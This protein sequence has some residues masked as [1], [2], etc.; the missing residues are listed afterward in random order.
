[1]GASNQCFV[2][3]NNN[4]VGNTFQ[5]I[6]CGFESIVYLENGSS[7]KIARITALFACGNGSNVLL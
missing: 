5:D 7:D 2:V 4:M 1:M 3:K 6:P